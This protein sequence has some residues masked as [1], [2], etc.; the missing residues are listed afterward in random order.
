M[1]EEG[2]VRKAYWTEEIDVRVILEEQKKADELVAQAKKKADEV[3]EEARRK[4]KEILAQAE[5]VDV[6]AEEIIGKERRRIEEELNALLKDHERRLAEL[7]LRLEEMREEIKKR[8]LEEL[9]R[10]A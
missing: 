6:D 4:A 2:G 9:T 8:V 7:K 10:W 5:A 1:G 3:L